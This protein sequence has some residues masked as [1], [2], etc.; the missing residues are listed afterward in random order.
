MLFPT[1]ARCV[2]LPGFLERPVVAKFG[3]SQGSSD[4]GALLLKRLL[5]AGWVSLR[6]WPR[7]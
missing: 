7:V 6:P 2:L 1:T 3:R 5:T 4:G